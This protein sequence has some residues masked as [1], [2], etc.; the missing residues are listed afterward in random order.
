MH[1]TY[2]TSFQL[3]IKFLTS[4]EPCPQGGALRPK[5]IN[6]KTRSRNKF[7]MTKGL[8]TKRHVMLNLFQH[9]ICLFS[10]FSRYTFH[11]RPQDGVFR[12]GFNKSEYFLLTLLTPSPPPSPQW[13]EGGGEGK[14]QIFLFKFLYKIYSKKSKNVCFGTKY[15]FLPSE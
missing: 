8:E 10:A 5:F 6:Q 2:L 1:I 9:L 11:P 7:G 3:E 4:K 13:G 12:C 15:A 14:F